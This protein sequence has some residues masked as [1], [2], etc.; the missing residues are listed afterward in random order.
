M[1][2]YFSRS[3][4]GGELINLDNPEINN[5]RSR[6]DDGWILGKLFVCKTELIKQSTSILLQPAGSCLLTDEPL[7]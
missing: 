1:A 6:L 5:L 2:I 3:P 4:I 7:S